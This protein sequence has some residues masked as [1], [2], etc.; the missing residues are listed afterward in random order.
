MSTIKQ[1]TTRQAEIGELSNGRLQLHIPITIGRR[2]GKSVVRLPDGA[3][4]QPDPPGKDP[5]Q[6]QL[7][8]ARGHRWWQMIQR[9][10]VANLTELAKQV[11]VDS[12]YVSR[13][14]NLT[15]LAPDIVAAILNETLPEHISLF[16][17]AVDPALLWDEQRERVGISVDNQLMSAAYE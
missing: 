9:R 1:I 6:L 2:N 3:I 4:R 8:L 13:M 10:E 14:V 15:N 16:D 12:S 11:G 7:A 5:T 17:L